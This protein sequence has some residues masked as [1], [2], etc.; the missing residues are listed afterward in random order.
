M[1]GLLNPSRSLTIQPLAHFMLRDLRQNAPTKNVTVRL[2]SVDAFEVL[3]E[4]LV[5]EVSFSTPCCTLKLTGYLCSNLRSKQ[6]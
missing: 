1:L 6:M 5:N 3:K 4:M 2:V